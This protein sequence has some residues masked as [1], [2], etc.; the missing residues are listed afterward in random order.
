[1]TD[2]E[3]EHR[4]LVSGDASAVRELVSELRWSTTKIDG[5]REDLDAAVAVPVWTGTAAT[6]FRARMA[7]LSQGS[8]M[9]SSMVVRVR[10]A[11]ETA[12]SAY[13]VCTQ[14]ADHYIAFWRNRQPVMHPVV[15][16]LLARI[17]NAHLL[18]VGTTYQ[19]QLAGI[20]AVL[21]GEEV[22]LD[23][24]DEDTR[25]W[26]E[27]GLAKNDDW[28]KGNDSGLG[29][30]IPNTLATGDDRGWIPQGLGYD[31]ATRSLLQAYYTHD[32]RAYLAVIDEI[33]GKEVGEVQ[34]GG[35]YDDHGILRSGGSLNHAGGVTVDGD[36]VYVTDQGTVYTYSLSDIRGGQPGATVDQSEPPQ[37]ISGTS[38]ATVKDG[39]LYSGDFENDK[40]Y[41]YERGPD[42]DWVQVGDPVDTPN[43]C[44]GVLVRDGEYVFS[45]SHGRENESALVV[46]DRD[47][48]ERG[49]PY[50]LP[51]MSQGVV[52]V[53][54]DLVV[55]YE[56]GADAYS[57]SAT[58][59]WGWFWGVPDDDSLW[60][61]P[62]MTRTPLSELG[63]TEDFEVEPPT[64]NRAAG[65]LDT[66]A[67]ALATAAATLDRL[68]IT[69]AILGPV[70]AA[71][72]LA[73]SA[74]T[75]VT[76]AEGSLRTGAAAIR[77]TAEV[78]VATGRDYTRTDDGVGGRFS[79]LTPP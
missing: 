60:A 32:D 64:L 59:G 13:D 57:E 30:L 27:Q 42:G 78:L 39:R 75:L 8:A 12:A 63:L 65:D 14:N 2:P 1:M 66:P 31:A 44:Q 4:R 55:S 19:D 77:R 11:L 35:D 49:D 76:S 5:A 24:L 25:E 61:N 17:V 33:T 21:D 68:S 22:D 62:Y 28:M 71:A 37:S 58:G 43:N 56:S 7:G 67:S 26:V 29:P 48:G 41:V 46:Q 72:D 52:E 38:Y 34:L 47:T 36:R 50:V 20:T 53:D 16:E 3:I 10:G 40:L 51:N 18:D 45:T 54:G 70:P 6:L 15:E 79:G 23:E 9:T 69:S 74:T 73:T